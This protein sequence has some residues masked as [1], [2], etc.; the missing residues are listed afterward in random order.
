MDQVV[1]A[2]RGLAF[3]LGRAPAMHAADGATANGE[4]FAGLAI[5]AMGFASTG[6]KLDRSS[7]RSLRA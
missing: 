7:H 1:H 6:G 2:F 4:E 3:D 5:G